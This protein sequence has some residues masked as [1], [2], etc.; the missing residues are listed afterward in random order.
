MS[1]SLNRHA[2]LGAVLTTFGDIDTISRAQIV[3]VCEKHNLPWPAWFVNDSSNR[4]GRGVYSLTGSGTT[5]P[6][7]KAPAVRRPRAPVVS[8]VEVETV[9]TMNDAEQMAALHT[10]EIHTLNLV[11][12][13]VS[14]YVPFGNFNDVRSIVRSRKFY[15]MYITGLSGNGKTMM[16][17]QV[18]AEEGRELIRVNVTIE[19][20]EDDLIGGFRLID[21]RTVWQ[22]GPVVIAMER[23]A[24]LLLDEV[25]LGS[26]KMMCLQPVMEG[27]AIFIKKINKVIYPA[28]GF[29]VIATAN[30]KGKGSEDGRFIGT[31][32]QNEA[33]LDR[34]AITLEQSYPAPKVEAKILSNVLGASGIEDKDFVEKL[35]L[36]ADIVRRSFE[37]GALSEIIST[38]RL[39][40]ICDAFIIFK[41]R[42]KAIE[43]CVNR[44]DVDTKNAF[45]DLYN[46]L[47][48]AE[49]TVN[50]APEVDADKEV[51][52]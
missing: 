31:N 36:W 40:N 49:E 47:D 13:K 50:P 8:R 11:P 48:A 41:N 39:V 10:A 51:E 34:Y 21:G 14:G 42:R 24:T 19:T 30:T 1:R 26:T 7:D 15:P 9:P 27:K 17:E 38:R 45:L 5:V 35:V 52:F 23:G 37:S 44:F 20:D 18:H 46:K 32:V 25:D 4:I 28:A 12:A 33:M 22:N 16:V 3:E 29:N 6:S 2:F 43:L